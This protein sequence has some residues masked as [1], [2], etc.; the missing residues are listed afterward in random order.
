MD[1][2]TIAREQ[3][4]IVIAPRLDRGLATP[5]EDKVERAATAL[6]ALGAVLAG[7][8]AAFWR[9]LTQSGIAKPSE[10]NQAWTQLRR[11]HEMGDC[12]D[13]GRDGRRHVEVEIAERRCAASLQA[14]AL[15][16]LK[17][18]E[19]PRGFPSGCSL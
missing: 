10:G 19:L 18:T 13:S 9:N 6:P 14:S 17:T 4:E 12:C 16:L 11:R 3:P 7:A 15:Q 5:A 8:A 1:Q 2:G